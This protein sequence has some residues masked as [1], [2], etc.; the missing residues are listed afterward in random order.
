[1]TAMDGRVLVTG[2]GAVTP[3]GGDATS[4]WEGLLAG[5]S[6]VTLLEG[7]EYDGFPVRLGAPAVFDP[8]GVLPERTVRKTDRCQQMALAAALEAWRDSGLAELAGSDLA[9]PGERLAV[10]IGSC[11]GGLTSVLEAWDALREKGV[12][13]FSPFTA[14]RVLPDAVASWVSLELGARAGMESP[15]AACATGN[16]SLRRGAELIRSGKA[17]VVVA[18]GT[19]A[20]LSPFGVATFTAMRALS[21]RNDEPERASRP[22]GRGRDGFVLGEGAAV[23]VLESA[24]HARRRGARAY[25]ELAGAGFSAD[26]HDFAQPDPSGAGQAAALREALAGAGIEPSQVVHVNAHAAGTPQGDLTESAAIRSVLGRYAEKVVV[27][28]TKSAIGHLM[29]GAGATESM[30]T[31]LA[32]HHRVV[33]PTLN[34]DDYDDEIGLDIA[35][36]PRELPGGEL[37]AVS[38]SFGLGGHNGIIAFR[39]V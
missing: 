26:G 34:Q 8:A 20:V 30:A 35:R 38:N 21:R 29:G 13:R 32:L 19:D 33:P 24:G 5:R 2:L 1:M 16:D 4:T 9:V 14:G 36:E 11:M 23:M 27:T 18:G 10:S 3:L 12:R 37:A 39:T 28:A 17:D 25:A 7:P 22:F 6:G 15:A 31:V